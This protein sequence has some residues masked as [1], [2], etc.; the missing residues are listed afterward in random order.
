MLTVGFSWPPKKKKKRRKSQLAML[1]IFLLRFLF[2][3]TSQLK[4]KMDVAKTKE[5]VFCTKQDQ[6]TEPVSLDGC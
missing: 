6:K 3:R 5:P 1:L 4:K 2:W